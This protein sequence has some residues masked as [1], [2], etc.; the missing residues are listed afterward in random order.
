MQWV[1]ER[2]CERDAGHTIPK[3]THTNILR[4]VFKNNLFVYMRDGLGFDEISPDSH[5]ISYSASLTLSNVSIYTI[6][7]DDIF[8][9]R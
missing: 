6:A 2:E 8:V 7:I 3:Y 4:V 1:S 9:R 5:S